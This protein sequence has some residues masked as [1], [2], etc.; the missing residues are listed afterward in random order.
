M[1]NDMTLYALFTGIIVPLLVGLLT[2][3]NASSGVKAFVNLT[4]T[5]IGTALATLQGTDWSWKIF[6]VNFGVGW[7]TS[8]ATY[9]G[10]YKPTGT[11]DKVADFTPDFGIG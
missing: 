10:F 4:L 7:A 6:A 11:S 1:Y 2:K 9:Y 8:I 3:V 5:A